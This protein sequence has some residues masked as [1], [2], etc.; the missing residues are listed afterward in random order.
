MDPRNLNQYVKREIFQIPTQDV[1]FSQLV[2]SKVFSL[3]DASSAFLQ[4]PLT[5]ESSLLCT[6]ATSFGR[7]RYLRLPYGISCAPEIFQ[8][9]IS[10]I[11]EGVEGV[12]SYFDDILVFGKTI[13][14]HNR[15]LAK[16]LHRIKTSG[17]TLNR[18]KS[19][20]C[21]TEV[22]F[23]GHKIN[24]DGIAPDERKTVAI[25]E[26]QSPKNKKDLQRF[27]G[28][29]VYL[30]KFIP[31]LSTETSSLRKLLS[32]TVE[33]QW[34][35]VEEK[36]FNHL[37]DLVSSAT[38]LSYFDP[39]KETTLSVDASPFG[40]GAVLWQDG[41]P[42]EFAS[43][44]LTPTQQRYN[45]IEKELLALVFGCERFNYYLFGLK[46]FKIESDHRPLL[47]LLKKPLDEMSPRI[48]RL[49]IRLLKYRFT[50]TFVPGKHL[51]V[52]DT[53]SREPTVQR[54]NTDYLD[55]DLKIYSIIAVRPETEK[56]IIDAI[57]NDPVLQKIKHYVMN[58]WPEHK[59]NVSPEL[60][61]YWS[62]KNDIYLH[63]NVLFYG[64]RLVLPEILRGEFLELIHRYHQG[65][66]SCKKLAEK[67]I[68]YPGWS[69]DVEKMVLSCPTCQLYSRSNQRQPLTPHEVPE[70][71]WQKIGIDFKAMG[72]QDFLVVVDYY[73]KFAIV[74]K[75]QNK[76]GS[77]VISVLKNIFVNHG[78]PQEI[79]SDNGP[80]FNSG[81]F[82]NFAK[83]YEI[84]L[85]T[86]SPYY[87]RS[88]G[89]VERTIQT[90]K[91]LLTKAQQYNED[92]LL[93]ILNYNVTPKMELPAPCELLMGRRLR[94]TLPVSKKLLQSTFP[95][96]KIQ[97]KLREMQSRQKEYYDQSSKELS[98]LNPGQHVI[99]QEGIR[100]WRPGT[101][102]NQN[103]P[104][105]YNIQ[106][107]ETEYRRNRQ[108]LRPLRE[109]PQITH[110]EP[111]EEN[112]S[113]ANSADETKKSEC[114]VKESEKTTV[115][116][117]GRLVK[118]PEKLNL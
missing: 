81:E 58:G 111:V 28:M 53:L 8:R 6:I 68:Y 12:L 43:V 99:V 77:H 98:V 60:K 109:P 45:H 88:N 118:A 21:V 46:N 91:G 20:F 71:P 47:G 25:R 69:S 31:N 70:L 2:G 56:K 16:V 61:K 32:N 59:S 7:Y 17:L 104:N 57:N 72:A 41:R 87:P 90:V 83:T 11:L 64:K 30:S 85:T 51:Q 37:K 105:D 113:S 108:S 3:L 73:S 26:M 63:M 102:I 52:P 79:F 82:Y 78:I 117:S 95:V 116:R 14:E 22:R 100:Q 13:E 35:C 9:C 18:E 38:T 103:R 92:P 94:T 40:L 24:S 33:W 54:V 110:E 39:E 23:L 101:V 34:T 89:M 93:A 42:I 50:L 97:K 49:A 112:V 55:S 84:K 67:C 29:I 66:V 96:S 114:S 10:E 76:T 48:Q 106:I 80:P 27:L 19:K 115:T 74:N 75:L 5:H 107:G 65:V 36:A 86:S 62:I 15:N 4:L 44:S 1:L